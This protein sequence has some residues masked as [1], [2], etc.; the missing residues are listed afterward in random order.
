MAMMMTGRVLLVCALCVLWCGA[1]GRC[2]GETAVLGSR[3]ELPPAPLETSQKGLQELQS[4]E[5]GAKGTASLASPPPPK[6]KDADSEDEGDED[7][8]ADE[9]KD[10]SKV[11]RTEGQSGEK[12]NVALGSDSGEKNLSGSEKETGQPIV[13]AEDISHS[14]SQESNAIP[15]QTKVEEKKDTDKRPPAV[16]NALTTGNGEHTL[17]GEIV[18]GNLPSSPEDGAD[19]R[20]QDGE[21]TTSEEKKDV[22]PP[23]TAAT[24]QSHQ[25][26][27]SE[28]TEEDT[29]ATTVTANTTDTTNTQ[30]SDSS[31]AASHTVSP[32]LLLLL[33]VACAA[34]AAVVAA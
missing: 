19:S 13:S 7:G 2:K 18:G 1:G 23:E 34:A 26:K 10:E 12:A 6:D 25:D 29:K 28:G 30:N 17:P 31:T 15:T 22:P 11:R 27:G 32:L 3:A 9:E 14:D 24:P 20:K 33:L 5:P 16:E 21:D 4:G 8:N